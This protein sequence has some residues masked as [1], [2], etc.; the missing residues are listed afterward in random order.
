MNSHVLN[1][2]F[3][4]LLRPAISVVAACLYV[5]TLPQ[6]FAQEPD[7]APAP[8]SN[9]MIRDVFTAGP[10]PLVVD[11]TVCLYVERDNAK[12]M[13]MFTMPEWLC[14]STENTKNW[15]PHGAVVSPAHFFW[16]DPNL[17]WAA[18]AVPKDRKCCYFLTLDGV[19]AP[20]RTNLYKL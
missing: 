17:A 4:R 14:F 9:P 7:S 8:G 19:G 11:N 15:T 3:A 16:G 6:S 20:P 2:R 12:D 18:Q 10:A 13:E 1:L 5:G